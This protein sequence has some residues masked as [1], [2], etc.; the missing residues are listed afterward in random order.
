MTSKDLSIGMVQVKAKHWPF[1]GF[2]TEFVTSSAEAWQL[3]VWSMLLL[4]LVPLFMMAIGMFAAL[5]HKKTYLLITGE[6]GIAENLQVFIYMITFILALIPTYIHWQAQERLIAVLYMSLCVGLLFLCG[7]EIS[8]GQRI[9]GWQTM[10]IFAKIN[11][12]HET[13]LHNLKGVQYLFKWVQLL[14]GAYGVFLP[15]IIKRW[16]VFPAFRS[17]FA[18]TIPHESLIPYFGAMFLWKLYRNLV[19]MPGRWEFRLAE[20]N[21]IIELL[22]ALGLFLF[23]VFQIRQIRHARTNSTNIV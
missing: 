5:F 3:P 12:Q 18:A 14:V 6:D 7:E 13:N 17:L 15:L 4:W 8:W 22:L 20:Y 10:G 16:N 11:Q 19:R 2:V 9:F 21:E 1:S 23:I